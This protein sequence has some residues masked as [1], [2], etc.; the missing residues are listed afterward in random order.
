MYVCMYVCMYIYIYIYIHIER[1]PTWN[2]ASYDLRLCLTQQIPVF[3]EKTKLCHM[4]CGRA[5]FT[6]VGQFVRESPHLQSPGSAIIF[7]DPLRQN[8]I[9][10]VLY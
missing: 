3:V 4:S 2:S 1:Y 6:R 9:D 7:Q 10:S 5:G 8:S